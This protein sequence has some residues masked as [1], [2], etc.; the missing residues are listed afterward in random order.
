ML[1]FQRFSLKKRL[2][3]LRGAGE[4]DGDDK[5]QKRFQSCRGLRPTAK[6]VRYD[7]SQGWR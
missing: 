2:T 1:A 5:G 6:N 7:V 3:I 4:D